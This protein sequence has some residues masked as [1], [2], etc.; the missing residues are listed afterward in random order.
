MQNE[1]TFLCLKIIF[2]IHKKQNEEKFPI[3]ILQE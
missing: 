2:K 1:R 3:S